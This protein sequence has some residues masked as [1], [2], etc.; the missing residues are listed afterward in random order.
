[1]FG[2]AR[3]IR[4]AA[5]TPLALACA[6]AACSGGDQRASTPGVQG[7]TITVGALVPL[8]DAVAVI[9][10]P[11]LAGL[12]TFFD[13]VNAS[14]GIGAKYHVKLLAEDIT[15][16]NP[17]SGAQKYQKI[18]DQ[19]SM[20]G[21]VIGTDQV[22]GLL[23][24]LAED[25]VIA[26]PTTFD[27]E[28]VRDPNLLPWG[29]PYQLQA[30][31]GV[32]YALTGAGYAGQPVCTMTLATGYGE[33]TVEGVEYL[34]TAMQFS[35]AA[36]ATFKQDDQDFVAPVTQLKNAGCAVVM[37]A[38][39]P[40]VTGKVLGAAAQLGFAPRW[41]LTSPSYH[42][43]LAASA[44]KDYLEKT[45]WMSWD[46]ATYGDTTMPAM[47]T[48]LAAQQRFM[49]QQKPD[50]YYQAGYVMGYAVQALLERAVA[51]GDLSRPGLLRAMTEIPTL[52]TEGLLRDWSYGPVAQRNPPRAGTIFKVSASAPLGLTV[53]QDGVSVPAAQSYTFE[54]R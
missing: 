45:T 13:R 37:M 30:I 9:G 54:R 51:N 42:H 48:M 35:V 31:N 20:F 28:W 15:Y 52:S 5:V 21:M 50:W 22:K 27:A 8:S 29:T 18:R 33:A 17:S 39:L 36:K 47:R 3:K 26:L 32:G 24:L 46:G 25:S 34:A 11:M 1:M 43:A 10:K 38:S 44:L 12:T 23:P 53:E 16:V 7:D 6:L 49:P 4:E 2:R 19:V 14:G 40:S 41:V